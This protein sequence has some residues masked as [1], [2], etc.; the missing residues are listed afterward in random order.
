MS[1]NLEGLKIEATY[2]ETFPIVG[3]VE[4]S[5]VAYGGSVKHTVVLDHPIKVYGAERN[6]VIIDHA[7]VERVKSNHLEIA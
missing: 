1:W 5:R 4:L 6:R 2:L 3:V 7:Q